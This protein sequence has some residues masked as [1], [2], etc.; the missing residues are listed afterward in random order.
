MVIADNSI[1]QTPVSNIHQNRTQKPSLLTKI[2][3]GFPPLLTIVAAAVKPCEQAQV[4]V[5]IGTQPAIT[6]CAAEPSTNECL[7]SYLS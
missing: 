6:A 7:V 3:V 1:Y 2:Y 4:S 5:G